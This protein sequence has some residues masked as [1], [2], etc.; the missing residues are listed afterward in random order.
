[1][2]FLLRYDYVDGIVERRTSFRDEHVALCHQA[3]EQGLLQMAG[4]LLEPLDGALLLFRAD[5]RAA[6]EAFVKRDPYVR[7]G[8]VTAWRI[9]PWEVVIGS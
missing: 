8:L 5:D 7:E 4:P 1:M 9:R 6:V 3:Q 2:H